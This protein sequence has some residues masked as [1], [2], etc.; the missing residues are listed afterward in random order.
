MCLH[1]T[2]T[3]VVGC[4]GIIPW[5]L[6]DDECFKTDAVEMIEFLVP[7]VYMRHD[8]IRHITTT[9]VEAFQLI[10]GSQVVARVFGGGKIYCP[11]SSPFLFT[12]KVEAHEKLCVNCTGSGDA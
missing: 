3:N 10:K 1:A 4:K 11:I 8:I 9:I 6:V 5:G 2:S 7:G 12:L